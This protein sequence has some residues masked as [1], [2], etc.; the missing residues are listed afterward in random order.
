[1]R[2]FVDV[3]P[4]RCKINLNCACYL[5]NQQLLFLSCDDVN[6]ILSELTVSVVDLFEAITEELLEHSWFMILQST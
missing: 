3:G 2:V 4:A 6:M 5:S 1:M